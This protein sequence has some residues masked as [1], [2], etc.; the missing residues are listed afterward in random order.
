ME[1]LRLQL[2]KQIKATQ[3]ADLKAVLLAWVGSHHD[4]E[5][6]RELQ[7]A[8]EIHDNGWDA[9]DKL[10]GSIEAPTDW[11]AEHNHYLYN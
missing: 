3:E 7:Q 5:D 10:V 4:E 6:I 1:H 11:A 9:I 2:P 8:F